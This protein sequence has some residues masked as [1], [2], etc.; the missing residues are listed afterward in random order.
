MKAAVVVL[1][2]AIIGLGPLSTTSCS[3]DRHSSDFTC[4]SDSDCKD[5]T[6]TCDRGYCVESS[7]DGCPSPCTSC[8]LTDLSCRIDCSASKPCGNVQC[9]LGFACTIRCSNA[10]AC[11]SIDCAQGASCDISCDGALACGGINCGFGQCSVDC[12]GTDACQT[13]DCVTSCACDVRC[14]NP[15][16][17]PPPSCPPGLTYCTRGAVPG[18][19]CDSSQDGCDRCP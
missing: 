7:S 14:N 11:G 18:A 12:A 8:D 2:L 9:P 4:T 6:R 17:C 19:T 3:V 13:I 15:E 1:V 16:A 10:S 5:S